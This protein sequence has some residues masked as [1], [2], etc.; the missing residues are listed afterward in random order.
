MR[1]L[2]DPVRSADSVDLRENPGMT[3]NDDLATW[4]DLEAGA[5][6]IAAAGRGVLSAG[7]EAGALLATV[8]VN[9]PPRIHPVSVAIVDGGLY[10]FL[11]D[12]A[13]RRDLAEDGRF[14]LHGY[15]DPTTPTEFSI[16][17]RARLVPAGPL[18]DRL[19]GGWSFE[20][21]DSYWL[22]ELRI[23]SVILG[24]RAADEWPPRYARWS[25]TGA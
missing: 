4:A 17:G 13:K 5:P 1:S 19:A 9:V 18:R 24:E 14:A 7:S 23:G 8:R 2:A 20:V 16:R 21:D 25:A 11:L 6:G 12:S 15:Q 22:F 10:V 3:T